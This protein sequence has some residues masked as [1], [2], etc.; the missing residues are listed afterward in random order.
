MISL[1]QNGSPRPDEQVAAG[2]LTLM[3]GGEPRRLP[4]LPIALNRQWVEEFRKATET[5][6]GRVSNVESLGDVA[7]QLD[8]NT[9]LMI[10]LLLKYDR[11]GQLGGREW[12]LE[13]VVPREVYDALRSVTEAAFP[14]GVDLLRHVPTIRATLM[15]ALMQAVSP[16][17]TN[18]RQRSTA[19]RRKRSNGS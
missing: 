4:V 1:P 15:A 6:I 12:T 9:D 2:Y 13:H 5:A 18:G 10:D 7:A 14:F 11:D 17:S 19:G 8:Q 3:W 16:R